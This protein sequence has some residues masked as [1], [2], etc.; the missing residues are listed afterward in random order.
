MNRYKN[1]NYKKNNIY[2]KI[3]VIIKEQGFKVLSLKLFN[4]FLREVYYKIQFTFYKNKLKYFYFNNNKYKYFYHPYN[5]TWANERSVEVSIIKDIIDNYSYEK[6]EILEVG[7]VLS[8]YFPAKWEIVDKFDD[9]GNSINA[10]IVDFISKHK[11]K[12]II[13]ISTIEHIG[14]DDTEKSEQKVLSALDNIIKNLLSKNGTF[15]ATFPIGYN[16]NLDEYLFEN[17]LIFSKVF[18]MKRVSKHNDWVE[19]Q[20]NELREVEYNSPYHYAN[21]LVIGIYNKE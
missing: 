4:F 12:L 6:N 3:F 9:S 2:Y 10:D 17:K 5:H 8:N 11:Y 14:F 16:K 20:L 19:V 18:C 21:G 15:V 13:S 1:F 7:N